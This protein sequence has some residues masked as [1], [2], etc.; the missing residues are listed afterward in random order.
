MSTKIKSPVLLNAAEIARQC[1][2]TFERPADATLRQVLMFDF[3]KVCLPVPGTL[4]GMTTSGERF[5]VEVIF[6]KYPF[7]VGRIDNDLLTGLLAYDDLIHF[8]ADN[9]YQVK[10]CTEVLG[11]AAGGG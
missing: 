7:F 1:P 2:D 10:D 4:A 11:K 6:A 8:H 9:I 3:A 5:W